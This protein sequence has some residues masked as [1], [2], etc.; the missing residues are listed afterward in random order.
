MGV[1]FHGDRETGKSAL[2]AFLAQESGFPFIK[3][4]TADLLL[5]Y[6]ENR[7]CDRITKIFDD[8][9]KSPRSIIILVRCQLAV[10]IPHDGIT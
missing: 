7:K 1:L 4:I 2:A 5:G 8:A 3:M 10:W 6:P 9:H